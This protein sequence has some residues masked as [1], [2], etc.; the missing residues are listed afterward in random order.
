ME[1]ALQPPASW[2]TVHA[3]AA[4]GFKSRHKTNGYVRA[5]PPRRPPFCRVPRSHPQIQPTN[6]HRG[7]AMPAALHVIEWKSTHPAVAKAPHPRR[8]SDCACATSCTN[9]IEPFSPS[10]TCLAALFNCM[11]G[12]KAA[13]H[14]AP[15][16]GMPPCPCHALPRPT[17]DL[18][19]DVSLRSRVGLE[20]SFPPT[21]CPHRQTS[22]PHPCSNPCNQP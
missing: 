6:T 2:I 4:T 21:Q 11:P 3:A 15:P 16:P 10:K 8:S 9:Q 1:P 5:T 20:C 7:R 19:Y 12:R 22:N 13:R 17:Q 14:A 18:W